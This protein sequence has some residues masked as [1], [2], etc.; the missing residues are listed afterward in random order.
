M[1]MA[2]SAPI[3]RLP[4]DARALV[5]SIIKVLTLYMRSESI[6]MLVGRNLTAT[7]SFRGG[8]ITRD[9]IEDVMA[10]L[11]FYKKYFAKEGEISLKLD[12]PEKILDALVAAWEVHRA[13]LPVPEV[14]TSPETSEL[15]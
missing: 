7:L 11:M 4:P 8:P 15:A 10:H 3:D 14:A 1:N 12:T 6:E 9:A 13:S 2:G 5:E